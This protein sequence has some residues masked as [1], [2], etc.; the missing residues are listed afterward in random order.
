MGK[1][2]SKL[3]NSNLEKALDEVYNKIL[4]RDKIKKQY[5]NSLENISNINDEIESEKNRLNNLKV[6]QV[7]K[8]VSKEEYI[9]LHKTIKRDSKK[10]IIGWF[11]IGYVLA[12]IIVSVMMINTLT[13]LDDD[14]KRHEYYVKL[15]SKL[16]EKYPSFIK[17]FEY[18]AEDY[19][20]NDV[21]IPFQ[22]TYV[23]YARAHD[24]I[25]IDYYHHASIIDKGKIEMYEDGDIED[26]IGTIFS[27]LF[28]LIGLLCMGLPILGGIL[29]LMGIA[30]IFG[31]GINYIV[32]AGVIRIIALAIISSIVLY[33][34][35]TIIVH[36]IN[37]KR[38]TNELNTLEEKYEEE[39]NK[40]LKDKEIKE[41]HYKD[42]YVKTKHEIEN[43]IK[44]LDKK[45]VNEQKKQKQIG[46]QLNESIKEVKI[47]SIHEDY[48]E[49]DII[50]LF[51]KYLQKGRCDTL[52]ECINLYE[53]EKAYTDFQKQVDDVKEY[54]STEAEK[55]KDVINQMQEEN[56]KNLKDVYSQISKN[57]EK[58]DLLKEDVKDIDIEQKA[59]SMRN[60]DNRIRYGGVDAE[61]EY[62]RDM[63]R[64]REKARK[65]K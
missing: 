61:N 33:I 21:P 53:Q 9:K 42:E 65:D 59:I 7:E 29:L 48:L 3:K 8:F 39:Y 34:I 45:L 64:Y 22:G 57:E 13:T 4:L 46:E 5:L 54:A 49:T 12:I 26:V 24:K 23:E 36:F 62:Q 52:K 31:N 35:K 43:N 15:E 56:R 50:L 51:K 27:A 10:H 41:K 20:E 25:G 55:S 63:D 11:I 19:D 60:S 30:I 38:K 1:D 17:N 58:L 47:M 16:E 18:S 44:D 28:I 6:E 40:Y 14:A 37:S 2:L 32:F